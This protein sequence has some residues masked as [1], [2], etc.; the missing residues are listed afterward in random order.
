MGKAPENLHPF[1]QHIWRRVHLYKMNFNAVF[2]GDVGSGKSYTALTFAAM[3][4]P[5]FNIE[6]VAFSGRE[7]LASMD[8]AQELKRRG[9]CIILEESGVNLGSRQWFS[10]QNRLLNEFQMVSRHL[11]MVSFQTVPDMS[12]IDAQQRRTTHCII[13]VRRSHNNPPIASPRLLMHSY[14]QVR[15]PYRYAPR[16]YVQG[17]MISFPDIEIKT[18]PPPDLMEAYEEKSTAWKHNLRK[19]N[20]SLLQ[21]MEQAEK[22]PKKLNEYVDDVVMEPEKYENDKG[23]IDAAFIRAE[24]EVSQRDSYSIAKLAKKRL[25]SHQ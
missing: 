8:K 25:K 4:D 19:G 3:L 18:L 17:Q 14:M 11:R 10:L 5:L 23:E 2:C 9:Q 6:K 16:A 13:K 22:P 1:L 20:L 15:D 21:T 24:F 12:F 7:F